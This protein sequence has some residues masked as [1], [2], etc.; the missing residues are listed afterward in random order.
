MTSRNVRPI[1]RAPLLTERRVLPLPPRRGTGR[2]PATG[3][4]APVFVLRPAAYR[5]ADR[6]TAA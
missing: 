2:P 4:L 1:E 6:G 3:W 5:P